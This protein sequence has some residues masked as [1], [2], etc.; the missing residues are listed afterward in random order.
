[1]TTTDQQ[2]LIDQVAGL[3]DADPVVEALWLAGSL[4][5]GGGDAFSDVDLLVLTADGAAAE[6]SARL[7]RDLAKPLR[8]VL[9]NSLHGGRVLSMVTEDWARFDLTLVQREDLG[10]YDAKALTAIFN[11]GDSAPPVQ[12]QTP[13]RTPPDQLLKMVR[14]FLRI[15]GLTPVA[16]GREEYQLALTGIDL[17]RRMTFDLMLEENSISPARRGGALHRNPMLT[18]EQR[19]DLRALP[20]TA[21]ERASIIEGTTAFARLFLPRARRLAT[22][23]GMDW[24]TTFEDSTRRHLLRK[25]LGVRHPDSPPSC[26]RLKTLSCCSNGRR[27]ASSPSPSPPSSPFFAVELTGNYPDENSPGR[28]AP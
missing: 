12:P 9:L 17:L 24:P 22:E 11:R 20:T 21:A 7:A 3:L 13:Y 1:M 5:A 28:P 14:E 6:V 25:D 18:A 15:V 2:A 16:M 10:R 4:G 23:I 19:A 27:A 8:V 26:S